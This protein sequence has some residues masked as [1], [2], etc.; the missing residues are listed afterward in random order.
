VGEIVAGQEVVLSLSGLPD[1]RVA[2]A[3]DHAVAC[4]TSGADRG[5]VPPPTP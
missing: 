4:P 3:A 5:P 1:L 2:V